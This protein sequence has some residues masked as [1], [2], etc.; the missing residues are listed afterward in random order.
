MD[1]Q[2]RQDG[3]IGD[4]GRKTLQHPFDVSD[5][6][7]ISVEIEIAA[8]DAEGLFVIE[9][10]K[11]GKLAEV[12]GEGMLFFHVREPFGDEGDAAQGEACLRVDEEPC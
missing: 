9:S 4:P 12:V 8:P 2:I 3:V 1:F 11:A 6:V 5:I 10:V 7:D